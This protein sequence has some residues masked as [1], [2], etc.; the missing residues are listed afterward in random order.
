MGSFVLAVL[1]ASAPVGGPA[2]H[3]NVTARFKYDSVVFTDYAEAYRL[4]V[5][6]NKTLV[7]WVAEQ[8]PVCVS[9]A[10]TCGV[11]RLAP[12]SGPV[13]VVATPNGK[14]E[15][16]Q[17]FLLVNLNKNVGEELSNYVKKVDGTRA[18]HGP[19]TVD[20]SPTYAP[21]QFQNVGQLFFGRCRNG[22]C[23]R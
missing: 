16:D 21:A 2:A 18:T 19:E 5:E 20:I 23:G 17:R 6:H 15:L 22:S 12:F 10:V 7:V 4:A 13:V 3:D 1:V 11:R 14:G 9:G 8:R